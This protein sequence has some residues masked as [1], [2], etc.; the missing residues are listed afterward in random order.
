M[1]EEVNKKPSKREL[2]LD[3]LGK[4]TARSVSHIGKMPVSVE[5]IFPVYM[6]V[7]LGDSEELIRSIVLEDLG[8][9]V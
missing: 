3:L 6:N 9:A 2:D 8:V 1:P 4:L 5:K 7:Q